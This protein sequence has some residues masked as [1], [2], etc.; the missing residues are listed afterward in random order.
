MS[1][2]INSSILYDYNSMELE[3]GKEM[4]KRLHGG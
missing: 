3:T 1:I 2:E 4:R